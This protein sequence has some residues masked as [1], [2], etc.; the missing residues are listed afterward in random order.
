[1]KNFK[2]FWEILGGYENFS[3]KN[4]LGGTKNCLKNPY[5]PCPHKNGS[6]AE[7]VLKLH[8]TTTIIE[9]NVYTFL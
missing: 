9:S 2:Q 8:H 6:P 3:K 4:V 1:M 7:K 5:T